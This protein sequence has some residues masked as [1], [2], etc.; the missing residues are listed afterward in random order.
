MRKGSGK[1]WLLFMVCVVGIAAIS[2]G[3][4]YYNF[5][6]HRIYEDSTDHLEEIYGQVN[7]SFGAFADTNWGLLNSWSSRLTHESG[8]QDE[9][10]AEFISGE[11]KNW[12]FTDFY[13]LS[14]DM[15]GMTLE[16]SE[17]AVNLE[18]AREQLMERGEPVMAGETLSGG[19]E[20]TVFAVPVQHGRYKDF[21]YDAI[22]ICY[23][24]ADLAVSL[25]VDAF[26]GK[27]RCFVIHNDGRVLLSTQ[28][29]GNVFENY[30]VYLQAVSDLDEEQ[31][32]QIQSDWKNGSAGL[33]QCEIGG[34]SHFI[35]YQPV[36]Y[37]DYFLLSAVPQS[38]VSSG[39][40]SIQ[41]ATM[42]MLLVI[43]LLL[44]AAMTA[45]FFLRSYRQ[46]RKSRMEL[47]YRERMFD[48]LSNSVDDIFIMLNSEDQH[49]DYISP[50]IE[51]LLGLSVGEVRENIKTLE[52]CA[53]G[54][55]IIIS[56]EELDGIA[57][58]GNR[59]WEYEY[60]HQTTG[61]RR[62]YRMTA[63]RMS[64][65][66][67]MKYIVV[68]SD[69]TLEKRMNQ[70][71]QE[72][73][74]AARSAN[75]AKSNFLSNMS[76]DIRTPM[77][78]I[79][80]FSVLLEKDAD[81]ADKVREYTRKITASSHHLLS[82]INDVLDMS[83]IESGKTSLNVD[84]F[85]L[86]ELLEELNIILMPQAKAKGQDFRIH[87]QGAPPEQIIGDKLRLNQI[88]INLL[89]NAIKYTQEGG[90][91]EF[92]VC[93]LPKAAPQFVKLRFVVKDNGIG[94]SKEFQEHIFAPFSR[95]ISSVTN[96]IQG[97]GLGMAI[98]K[99]LVDLMGGIIQVESTP[100]EGST[101]TVELSFAIPEQAD[102]ELW[103][104]QKVTRVLVADDEEEIC[105][106]V[107]EMMRDTGVE[108][109]YVTDGASA[110]GM[111]VEAHERG[112][113]YHVI[114]L[115][116]KMPGMN[117]VE[118]ARQIREKVGG[119]I[120]ILVLTSYDWSEIETEARQAGI[121]AFMPKPFFASTFWQTIRPMFYEYT[122]P[123]DDHTETAEGVMKGR[124]FLVAED[125]ELNAEILTEMLII[126]GAQ[127][128]LAVNGQQ[129][130]EMFEKSEPGYYDMI[131][132]D[133]QMPV[134]NG[135]EATRRIRA[136][137]HPK[138]ASIPIAAMTANT[139]A[140]DVRDA[141]DAGMDGHLAKPIDMDAV[142]QL[143][144]RLLSQA[145]QNGSELAAAERGN[146]G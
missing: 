118:T 92:T 119:H 12:G 45:M 1:I 65:Q 56:K 111:A 10:F 145:D 31:I 5:I 18:E 11:Q 49:V 83:K 108:V 106:D 64:I 35:L 117:G 89:S 24:N 66:D 71:L 69:R 55:D 17:E 33:L 15:T 103:Y 40:L 57:L 129:A 50:N 110:V 62:F 47:Q 85:S 29:G 2:I 84:R 60:M 6:S 16:G 19:Q 20:V 112:E 113:D 116:W 127:S 28:E 104:S 42:N 23:T 128:E 38:A 58:N 133:V 93:E 105:L 51:R 76:H 13:F 7:R 87:T 68:L 97:T 67:V 135:Y 139:F 75:E 21:D 109:S 30:L 32:A 107:K 120:P 95:E 131:L 63:Y 14:K 8:W 99:N 136:C 4:I 37:Q 44:G 114:L 61:E 52:K 86:P 39:F 100:G 22:A 48:V 90:Q 77:N 91:I 123:Q 124:R 146:N 102:E 144:G 94:I 140:E 81:D 27:G 36:G 98:T 132:M 130:L 142:R 72:A 80:G 26:S 101:F 46:S 43:F 82:L 137:R 73:L 78:A 70:Q 141:M 9:E 59:D 41:K 138:A 53:I 143:V 121:N 122:E 25:N 125:N 34:S 134:M 79:V 115:D 74:T 3:I 126:E 54:H 88:L 96:K